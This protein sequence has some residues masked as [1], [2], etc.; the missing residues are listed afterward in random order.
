[1]FFIVLCHESSEVENIYLIQAPDT[2]HIPQ[3]IERPADQCE[4]I[5]IPESVWK[6]ML[7]TERLVYR[8][9]RT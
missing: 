5:H 2:N 4:F 3:L 9:L 6:A 1:M 8:T 7:Y